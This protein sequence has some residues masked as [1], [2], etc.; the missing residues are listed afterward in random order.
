MK[1]KNLKLNFNKETIA[2]LGMNNVKGGTGAP[3]VK[4]CKLTDICTKTHNDSCQVTCTEHA[5]SDNPTIC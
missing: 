4:I 2:N 3:S 5:L 1:K